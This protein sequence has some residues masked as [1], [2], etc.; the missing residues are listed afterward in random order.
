MRTCVL[1]PSVSSFFK[2]WHSVTIVYYFQNVWAITDQHLVVNHHDG[3]FLFVV[4]MKYELGF[5]VF[6]AFCAVKRFP[7]Q[8]KGPNYKY[9]K[10]ISGHLFNIQMMQLLEKKVIVM[11]FCFACMC[12]ICQWGS[13]FSFV[14]QWR[15]LLNCSLWLTYMCRQTACLLIGSPL[16]HGNQ[17]SKANC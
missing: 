15:C 14:I 13:A 9:I 3:E 10:M 4:V 1:S 17:L 6:A 7:R 8:E 2:V 16:L 12:P 11:S 5:F